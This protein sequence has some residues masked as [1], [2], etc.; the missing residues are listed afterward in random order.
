MRDNWCIGYS[1]KYTVGVW[2][3]NFSGQPMRNVSGVTGAA[4]VWLEIMNYL[5]ANNPSI[6]PKKPDGVVLAGISFA[7]VG[8]GAREEFFLKGTEP[9]APVKVS[10][11]QKPRITYPADEML[12]AIDPEIP[13]NSQFVPFQ[14]EP[15]KGKFHWVINGKSLAS[16]S[17]VVL[18]KPQRGKYELS[19]VDDKDRTVDKVNFVVR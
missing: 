18:W 14:F 5:H 19:I 6:Q 1:D 11:Y 9:V 2:V 13:E 10:A 3:G 8:E 7:N 4:P 12:I 17:S 15:E 16:S